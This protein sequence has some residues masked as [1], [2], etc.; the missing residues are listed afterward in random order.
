MTDEYGIE[1]KNTSIAEFIQMCEE[2]KQMFRE[3]IRQPL[4][5]LLYDVNLLP[6]CCA[7]FDDV[8]AMCVI[9]ALYENQKESP[10]E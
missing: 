2:R 7:S 4:E 3:M 5:G 1:W 9:K 6:E 8:Q 10:N